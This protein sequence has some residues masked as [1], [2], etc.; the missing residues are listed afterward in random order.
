[1]AN[2]DLK[3]YAYQTAVAKGLDPDLFLAQIDQESKWDPQ[4]VSP[5]GAQGLL[6]FMPDTAKQPG[7]GVQGGFDPFDPYVAI[8]RGADYMNAM[9]DRY[10][11][12]Y[13]YALAA[14]NAGA[15]NVDKYGG[16]P[17]F[18]ETQQYVEK[19]R[20]KANLGGDSPQALAATDFQLAQPTG[21]PNGFNPVGTT[22]TANS[23]NPVVAQAEQQGFQPVTPNLDSEFSTLAQAKANSLNE[24][25]MEKLIRINS[26]PTEEELAYNAQQRE[27]WA[28]DYEMGTLDGWLKDVGARLVSG[29]MSVA[30]SVVNAPFNVAIMLHRNP[31]TPEDRATL[32]QLLMF[33]DAVD[34]QVATYSDNVNRTQDDVLKESMAPFA[35]AAA[36][37]YEQGDYYGALS[38]MI[39]APFVGASTNPA[40]ALAVFAESIPQMAATVASFGG[41]TAVLA[42]DQTRILYN[43]FEEVNKTKPNKDQANVIYGMALLNALTETASD[44]L[45]VKGAPAITKGMG[46]LANAVGIPQKSIA[47][48]FARGTGS[49]V[50]QVGQETI[51]G[52]STEL[53]RQY[54]I[55]QADPSKIDTGEIAIQAALEGA[56]AGPVQG[57]RSGVDALK[58]AAAPV[59]STLAK[60]ATEAFSKSEGVVAEATNTI[61]QEAS[62]IAGETPDFSETPYQDLANFMQVGLEEIKA[63]NPDMSAQE[64]H[65]DYLK[66]K[67]ESLISWMEDQPPEAVNDA[68]DLL[69]SVQQYYGVL[70]EAKKVVTLEQAGNY[71][72]VITNPE[73][74]AEDLKEAQESILRSM[75]VGNSISVEAAETLLGSNRFNDNEK[76]VITDY[77]ERVKS[78][79]EVS[80]EVRAGLDAKYTGYNVRAQSIQNALDNGNTEAAQAELGKMK[81]NIT[82][83][84]AKAKALREV[85]IYNYRAF[86]G[87]PAETP[88][89]LT[90]VTYGDKGI[91]LGFKVAN[92]FGMNPAKPYFATN[93]KVANALAA[94]IDSEVRIME[95]I[96]NAFETTT[97]VNTP[98]TSST[99]AKPA[100][101]KS[102]S[103]R[104]KT[105]AKT[106][107][108][109]DPAGGYRNRTI[110]NVRNADITVAYANDHTTAG[111]RL[112]KSAAQKEGK[113]FVSN[114]GIK[115][116]GQFITAITTALGSGTTINFAG[117]GIYSWGKV[118]QAGLNLRTYAILK[119]VKD[120]SNLQKVI[121]GGQTGS[122]T[123][124]IVAARVLGLETEVLMPK[125]F[126]QRG[127]DGKDFTQTAEQ[128]EAE[129]ARQE[130]ELRSYLKK[131]KAGKKPAKPTGK[132]PTEIPAYKAKGNIGNRPDAIKAFKELP[133][134]KKLRAARTDKQYNEAAAPF[135]NSE[136]YND[137]LETVI[138]D[139]YL[140]TD[141]P[142]MNSLAT[143]GVVNL[144]ASLVP[145]INGPTRL[146]DRLAKDIAERAGVYKFDS[147][148]AAYVR[149][150]VS[151]ETSEKLSTPKTYEV[152]S[153]GDK[154]FSALYAKLKDGRTIEQ[155]WAEAK[156]Y[157]NPKAA[158]NKPAKTKGFK[159]WDTYLGLWR[160]WAKENPDLIEELRT[161]ANGLPLS[162]SFAKTENN[163][164]R[165]LTIILEETAKPVSKPKP[166]AKA[167]P[168]TISEQLELNLQEQPETFNLAARLLNTVRSVAK[169]GYTIK[170]I[171]T[172][173]KGQQDVENEVVEVDENEVAYTA[174]SKVSAL[175]KFPDFLAQVSKG[176]IDISLNETEAQVFKGIVKWNNSLE[177]TLRTTNKALRKNFESVYYG[178]KNKANIETARSQAEAGRVKPTARDDYDNDPFLYLINV[179]ESLDQRNELDPNIITAM[180]V[181]MLN[182]IGAE[183]TNTY[184]NDD[185]A[186]NSFGNR[187][188][189]SPV[190][191]Q[192]AAALRYAGQ[193]MHKI[194]QSIGKQ[195]INT[196]GFKVNP[197]Y[198]DIN[199]QNRMETAIGMHVVYA[200]RDMGLLKESKVHV[201]FLGQEEDINDTKPQN[202]STFFAVNR[203][204]T[205]PIID[206]YKQINGSTQHT[207][208]TVMDDV[209]GLPVAPRLPSFKPKSG[210][211]KILRT[212]RSV[213]PQEAKDLNYAQSVPWTFK[214]EMRHLITKENRWQLLKMLG[215]N[216]EIE[217]TVALEM[218]PNEHSKNELMEREVD[219]LIEFFEL[220][221]ENEES[222]FFFEYS[223]WSNG[224]NGI[225][226]TDFNP[227]NSKLIRHFI[228]AKDWTVDIDLSKPE[229]VNAFMY[230]V[231]LGLGIDTD[232]EKPTRVFEQLRSKWADPA[233]QNALQGVN[234]L[235]E[236]PANTAAWDDVNAVLGKTKTHGL[237]ALIAL[238]EFFKA[239]ESGAKKFTTS[240]A[241]ETDAVTS[242]VII[243]LL[244]AGLDNEDVRAKLEA[245]GVFFNT[246]VSY[247]HWKSNKANLD[248]YE[249]LNVYWDGALDDVKLGLS[250]SEKKGEK[251][252]AKVF[253]QIKEFIGELERSIAKDPVLVTNYGAG[254]KSTVEAF[255]DG[256]IEELYKKLADPET[257]EQTIQLFNRIVL[258]NPLA[259]KGPLAA[260]FDVITQKIPAESLGVFK[261]RLSLSYGSALGSALIAHSGTFTDFQR[262][263]NTAINIGA[264]LFRAKLDQMIAD[265]TLRVGKELNELSRAEY[266]AILASE[267][268]KP[269]LPY[270]KF[271][272]SQVKEQG[273]HG[274]KTESVYGTKDTAVQISLA[275]PPNSYSNDTSRWTSFSPVGRAYVRQ[276][277]SPGVSGLVKFI[278]SLDAK[279]MRTILGSEPILSAFD[280]VFANPANSSRLAQKYSQE[281]LRITRDFSITG[282]VLETVQPMMERLNEFSDSELKE[283][284]LGINGTS[285]LIESGMG[286]REILKLF[287]GGL[288]DLHKD[289]LA[290][291]AQMHEEIEVV[292]HAASLDTAV[293]VGKGLADPALTEIV[294]DIAD[295]YLKSAQNV[296]PDEDFQADQEYEITGDNVRSVFNSLSVIGSVKTAASHLPRLE[297]VM[298][299][300]IEKVLPTLE[301]H[302]LAIRNSNEL[303]QGWIRNRRVY[304]NLGTGPIQHNLEMSGQEVMAHEMSH[305]VTKAGLADPKNAAVKR[306]LLRLQKEA[307]VALNRKFNGEGWRIFLKQDAN[308][309]PIYRASEQQEIEAAKEYWNY[310]FNGK[311]TATVNYVD[312]RGNLRRTQQP[313]A[314]LEFIALGLTNEQLS[315]ALDGITFTKNKINK[316][317]SFFGKLEELFYTLLDKVSRKIS[318]TQ[319]LPASQALLDLAVELNTVHTKNKFSTVKV[320]SKIADANTEV[321]DKWM[322]HILKPLADLNVKAFEY[323]QQNLANDKKTALSTAIVLGT[324]A[325]GTVLKPQGNATIPPDAFLTALDKVRRRM[326]KAKRGLA[327]EILRQVVP[328]ND[329]Y[330]KKLEWMH[331]KSKNLLDTGR[332][333]MIDAVRSNLKGAFLTDL[334]EEDS[335]A[336]TYGML[337]TDVSSLFKDPT[338]ANMDTLV[339]YLRDDKA[340][341]NRISALH[342]ELNG[343]YPT[344]ANYYI[345]QSRSLGNI[346]MRGRALMPDSAL[347]AYNI[348]NG[349]LVPNFPRPSEIF[350]AERLIDE[351]ASL[352]A[353]NNM[354]T[355][356][357]ATF[358]N[359]IEREFAANTR[360]NGIINMFA[361]QKGFKERSL[362]EN[363][364]NKKTMMIKGFIK[365]KTNPHIEVRI[366]TLQDKEAMAK[367]NFVPVKDNVLPQDKHD[368]SRG[369]VLY[370]NKYAGLARWNKTILS[371]TSEQVAG[372]SL[373]NG[374][375]GDENTYAETLREIRRIK[376]ANAPYV[377]RQMIEAQ[378]LDEDVWMIPSVNENGE[379]HDYRYMMD[380]WTRENL[381][382][383]EMDSFDLLA[384]MHG[385]VVDKVNTKRI[386]REAID[387]IK[388]DMDQNYASMPTDFVELGPF[389]DDPEIQEIYRLLPNDTKQYIKDTFVDQ[390]FMVRKEALVMLFG[391]R[392]MQ[393]AKNYYPR[394]IRIAEEVWKEI[395]TFAKTN[396]VIKNP[397]IITGNIF[398]NTLAGFLRGVPIEQMIK[399][400]LKGIR[401]LNAYQRDLDNLYRLL[402]KRESYKAIGK[403]I[404][405]INTDIAS[406]E[407]LLKNSEI[408]PL[409]NA[410][411][412][413]TIVEDVDVKGDQDGYASSYLNNLRK[414]APGMLGKKANAIEAGVDWAFLTR[415]TGAF[416][417]LLKGT[418]YSDFVAR[419]AMY[420]YMTEQA[421]RNQRKSQGEALRI[422]LDLFINYEMPT[423]RY[424]QYADDVGMLV[425][426]KYP[427]RIIRALYSAFTNNPLNALGLLVLEGAIDSAETPYDASFIN[428]WNPMRSTDM[429]WDSA[430]TVPI[431]NWVP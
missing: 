130:A 289:E 30:G 94:Q 131:P 227:Q 91:I 311:E 142:L 99:P 57:V 382:E 281:L 54:A 303:T 250:R 391:N 31:D 55:H 122:D 278:Q 3:E 332:E 209:F 302:K 405:D 89:G 390:P 211:H 273:L 338:K 235:L 100:A 414:K 53:T 291:K 5:A 155:A 286:V 221:K 248:N 84:K 52:G 156:G 190:D 212:N 28:K 310:V 83:Q 328:T 349:T 213:S 126:K 205:K 171:L 192:A 143:L 230:A 314:L 344:V 379:I 182:W 200:M 43:E 167:A 354:T 279:I 294:K 323:G 34:A 400:Q 38:N 283:V 20:S 186:V 16:I 401:L 378:I 165:A 25:A 33:T 63:A 144:S 325:A 399:G 247:P 288:E 319:D 158:K 56:A 313:L 318:R 266:E 79:A 361:S 239:K 150:G 201:A 329:P 11:G 403:D 172:L 330:M 148:K 127:K 385:S 46:A 161:A 75:R 42:A 271:F 51:S 24:S 420:E 416:K 22:A 243:G 68:K 191:P 115:D 322:R 121:S 402:D 293:Y 132:Y 411:L 371:L 410:G 267:E 78:L 404:T 425:F 358:S 261:Y 106:V 389:N 82:Y 74:T 159:Y 374:R 71:L 229:Q 61:A 363:F 392:K 272:D 206:S 242:G 415:N 353:L 364:D 341:M 423:N 337:M 427:T 365:D 118:T 184:I 340:L 86:T 339:S 386:N 223:T 351:L 312:S 220:W 226:S 380:Q 97:E 35:Q 321:Q 245:G 146:R 249:K 112:T 233:M 219:Q 255:I 345:N 232:K 133:L 26:T 202:Y 254:E 141:T 259:K 381:L 260:N 207:L 169:S 384:R 298:S 36:R 306:E 70:G 419:Y 64:L 195:V 357:K 198:P 393:I 274:I 277:A 333:K 164:A 395:V 326:G 308:G 359:I 412:F 356:N 203:T 92:D 352:Y 296:D 324:T 45:F 253:G 60:K 160:Q 188:P 194:A 284:L 315:K 6:Q 421:P 335:K 137:F 369:R 275:Y 87:R 320:M 50:G 336:L 41:T 429:M 138:K 81:N 49:L 62:K 222:D 14:Y 350:D 73:S 157:A 398:S 96:V 7:F 218:Q 355:A 413:Q 246:Y 305:A 23:F 234:I 187:N 367:E 153:R 238:N 417:L 134:V 251:N 224:R 215:W 225:K 124:A 58:S 263:V 80:E 199:F 210:N 65:E 265:R 299:Q 428:A 10:Q 185:A 95:G 276:F 107:I 154:R 39:A 214:P 244:T 145:Y 362:R 280:A 72:D 347:N 114:E 237:D 13:D 117:N 136:T 252:T 27:L 105:A 317:V 430:Q 9:L 346:M 348:A 12:N 292:D 108:K 181:A 409:I 102:S 334:T 236:D 256:Q 383:Q 168:K 285:D 343:R 69:A 375:I 32:E 424:L 103:E 287:V 268:M 426:L 388:S 170:D 176:S 373:R 44:K 269:F 88:A 240:I 189:K 270:Y 282:S 151:E 19:I 300:L 109:E 217:T 177:K 372:S 47:R 29:T 147:R 139:V 387:V 123:A 370:V 119:G 197:N 262:T 307:K 301:P 175:R 331:L 179:T 2:Q 166:K 48:S 422:I 257:R 258:G 85:G 104:N 327:Y 93:R 140:N 264:N 180:N 1:M 241:N 231:A 394:I 37:A 377:Q 418:Q 174:S 204:A 396:I 208:A 101:K 17:P 40:A 408:A 113:P 66:P 368:R 110:T 360:Y 290:Q 67:V 397:A 193:P 125:G 90:E 407:N 129:L 76:K 342:A 376:N 406:L 15:G 135:E 111:E 149:E 309:N 163:Q 77:I 297:K 152:S 316:R 304:I 173:R 18:A 8:D 59:T 98:N 21:N 196:L 128:V 116:R 4:A 295:D 228:Q 178:I 120:A 183:G 216:Y 366:G 431:S 162:D